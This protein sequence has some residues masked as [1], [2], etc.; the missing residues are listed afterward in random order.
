MEPSCMHYEDQY[1]YYST[2]L[3]NSNEAAELGP[4]IKFE[5]EPKP[6]NIPYG[7]L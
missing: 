6:K 3:L 2:S 1:L 4:V 7:R 5:I